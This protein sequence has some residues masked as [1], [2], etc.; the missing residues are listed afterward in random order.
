MAGADV[1]RELTEAILARIR[2]MGFAAA[3]VCDARPSE[4]LD[5]IRRWVAEGRHGSMAWFEETLG[6]RLDP[7]AFVAG[8]RSVICVADRYAP[9]RRDRRGDA[10][11]PRGR[12]ARYARGED[13][14]VVIQKR[15][16]SLVAALRSE[17]P[18]HTFRVACDL[19]PVLEREYAARAGLGRI[20]KHTL[21]IEDGGTSYVLLGEIVTTLELATTPRCDGDPCSSCTRCID[22]CPTGAIEPYAVDASKCIS[23]TTIEHRGAIDESL[24][25]PTGDW[26]FGCDVCQEVCPHNAPTRRKKALPILDWYRERL[27]DFDLLGVLGWTEADRMAATLR[28]A[29]RRCLL[30][31][32]KRNALVCLGNALASRRDPAIED[33]IRAI[34]DDH[35]EPQLVR[36][37]AR[38]TLLRIDAPAARP[39]T[40]DRGRR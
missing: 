25:E 19:L 17:H 29:T 26:I 6:P 37:E 12:V 8:A 23:Y 40:D 35:R 2:A 1:S 28:S 5:F 24:L 33:R 20:G 13:Y 14:H 10:W 3:G 38:R 15:L 31:T 4:H 7:Q 11:P 9:P 18:G 21:L 34:A 22:A 32:F 27:V 30:E 16:R 39:S 36:D